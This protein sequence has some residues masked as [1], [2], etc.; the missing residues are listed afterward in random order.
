MFPSWLQLQAVLFD[1]NGVLVE[2]EP[3]G[4]AD[5]LQP[6]L[7]PL[8]QQKRGAA[9]AAIADGSSAIRELFLY[10]GVEPLFQFLVS[11]RVSINIVTNGSRRTVGATLKRFQLESFIERLVTRDDV[12]FSK[13]HPAG[14]SQAVQALGLLP[15]QCLAVEDSPTG[16]TAALSAGLPAVAISTHFS[17]RDLATPLP[18][19]PAL[20]P[21]WVGQSLEQF[22]QVLAA[23]LA[24]PAS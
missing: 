5:Q 8:R 12:P 11:R 10:P 13:P 1:F 3:I 15:E 21:L 2:D 16:L 24:V 7:H 18:E 4:F 9:G 23:S 14:Y 17:A 20:K 19:Q 22:H 6:R